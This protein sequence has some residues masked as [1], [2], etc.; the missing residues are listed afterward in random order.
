MIPF[1]ENQKDII[2]SNNEKNS[3]SYRYGNS[4]VHFRKGPNGRLIQVVR[5]AFIKIKEL[6]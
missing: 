5:P 2:S 4:N 6:D 3:F 1:N